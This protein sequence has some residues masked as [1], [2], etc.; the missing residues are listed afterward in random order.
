MGE[1][2]TGKSFL[3]DL[4]LRYLRYQDQVGDVDND[5]AQPPR[6][7]EEPFKMP[8]WMT[9]TDI[10]HGA[11]D[12]AGG[13]RFKAGEAPCTQGVWIWSEPFV[14]KL[15]GQSVAL[16][17]MDTQGAWDSE[18]TKEQSATIF[19]LTAVLSSKQIYN[20]NMQISEVYI[21]NLVFFMQF[22]QAALRKSAAEMEAQGQKVDKETVER[23]FM[24]LDFLVRDWKYF[25]DSATVD[26]CKQS[27]A[28]HL[29]RHLKTKKLT[30]EDKDSGRKA[31]VR[32]FKR[33]QCR[34]MP[35]PGFKI[36]KDT[37]SGAIR[38]IDQ[39][40]ARFL[41][42]YVRE[43]F[44]DGLSTKEIL[45][46]EMS[47]LTFPMILKDFVKAF[48]NAS[49]V[50]MSFCQAMTNCTVLMA[51]EQAMKSYQKKMDDLMKGNP[52]GFSEEEFELKSR[53][54]SGLVNNEFNATSIFGAEKVKEDAWAE[55]KD[56]LDKM[57]KRYLEDNSRLLEKALV[58]LA[59][60]ALLGLVLFLLDRLSD[61]VC[62]WWLQM[63]REASN[64][65]ALAYVALFGYCGFY[66]YMLYRDR[67]KMGAIV[68]SSELWK[69]MMRLLCVYGDVAKTFSPGGQARDVTFTADAKQENKKDK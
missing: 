2:R 49:P 58:G 39:D 33:I 47:T 61:F 48:E 67:G 30:D 45:G 51:K 37:W 52:R 4:F 9:S 27:M 25:K 35:H 50:A 68:A 56:T 38:D 5:P 69:E 46:S 57:Q 53:S 16:L 21:D 8:A 24:S 1:M 3:L 41:D 7:G 17:L 10:I 54:I 42:M 18:M 40:F 62:D 66:V 22:A 26:E 15:D 29:E 32:M 20:I 43:V 6:G 14:R 11:Q 65:L 63:C 23:P 13:F 60:F 44:S 28:D 12:T 36:E 19:G 59:N 34:C 31:L 64:L 55:V